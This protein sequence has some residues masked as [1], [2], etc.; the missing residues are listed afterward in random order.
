VTSSRAD[1]RK[2]IRKQRQQLSESQRHEAALAITENLARTTLFR[3]SHR[4]AGFIANDGEP[5]LDPL[6]ELAWHR[7]KQWHLPIIGLPNLNHLWFGRYDEDDALVLNRYGIPEP[8]IALHQ[9][10]PAWGLDL[11][12][13]PLVAFDP[14]GNRLGMGKGYYDRTLKF[15]RHRCHWRKPRLVGI[16]YEFQKMEQLPNQPWDIPLDAIVTE[17]SV[18][19]IRRLKF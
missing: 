12:L 14:Q 16:A 10:T 8:A 19:N 18:Y 3:Q 17:Q 7:R 4:I 5:T 13:M 1:I 11:V 15:L 2:Q 9:T 6:M